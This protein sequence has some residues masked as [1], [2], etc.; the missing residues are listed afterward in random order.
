M[1]KEK[2]KIN[3][4]FFRVM[5]TLLDI[6]TFAFAIRLLVNYMTPDRDM[7]V[8][9]FSIGAC[10]YLVT[11][12]S[13][14]INPKSRLVKNLIITVAYMIAAFIL[15]SFEDFGTAID[16]ATILYFLTVVF[17]RII[18]IVKKHKVIG[19]IINVL[20]ILGILLVIFA[21][22]SSEEW[23]SGYSA[24]MLGILM[25]FQMLVRVTI[26]SFSHIRYD[27]LSK[28]IRKSMA[29]EILTGLLI[30]IVSF[31]FAFTAIGEPGIEGY[32]DALWYC[33]A[34]VT[35]IGFGDIYAVTLLGR[36][37]SVILG[38]YGIIVVSLITSIIVNFYT[39]VNKE[40]EPEK[41][42]GDDSDTDDDDYLI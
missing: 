30:L 5:E 7:F 19:T 36:V 28:V 9:V 26:L 23:Y 3:K 20:I 16:G 40:P 1:E 39:E 12:I 31:S 33:F 11:T 24:M 37:L 25:P 18:A 41:P 34:I 17:S 10:A 22:A 15:I 38:L 42:E 2:K 6:I 4:T 27:I 13:K 21:I 29:V 14:G 32:D 35:T 8:A